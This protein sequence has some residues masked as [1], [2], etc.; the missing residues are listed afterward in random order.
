MEVGDNVKWE[1]VRGT[2]SGVIKTTRIIYEVELPGGK[3]IKAEESSL[4]LIEKQN[5]TKRL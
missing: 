3:I 4:T 1:T 5:D 2:R